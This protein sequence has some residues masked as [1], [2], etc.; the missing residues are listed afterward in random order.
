MCLFKLFVRLILIY[1]YINRMKIRSSNKW[2]TALTNNEIVNYNLALTNQCNTE[3]K[4]KNFGKNI[5]MDRRES[6]VADLT[7]LQIK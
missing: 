2:K 4:I 5:T 6:A 3:V 7:A 1:F